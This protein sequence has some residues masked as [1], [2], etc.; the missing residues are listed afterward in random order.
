MPL[1]TKMLRSPEVSGLGVCTRRVCVAWRYCSCAESRSSSCFFSNVVV[2]HAEQHASSVKIRAF[3]II[4]FRVPKPFL[5][6]LRFI[7][8]LSFHDLEAR[9]AIQGATTNGYVTRQEQICHLWM[10]SILLDWW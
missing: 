7:A 1:E 6:Y 2:L 10:D 4:I 9:M 3:L 8:K 5:K